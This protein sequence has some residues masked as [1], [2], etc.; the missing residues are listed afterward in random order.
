MRAADLD[1][2]PHDAIVVGAG[3]AGAVTAL[4]LARHGYRVLLLDRHRFPRAKPCG[5]CLSPEAAR[6]LDRLGLLPRVAALEPARLRGWR[7]WSPDGAWFRGD[8]EAAAR[9]DARAETSI[10]VARERLDAALLDA[11][12]EAGVELRAPVT[13]EDLIVGPRGVEGIVGRTGGTRHRLRA[14]LVVGADGLRSVVAR[15][16]GATRRPGALRKV[17]F[18][19]HPILPAGFSGDVGEM[20]VVTGGCIGIAPVEA[21]RSGFPIAHNVT[22]VM[23]R[24]EGGGGMGLDPHARMRSLAERAPGLRDR[25]PVLFDAMA[26]CDSPLASGPFDRPVRFVVADGLA[27]VGD[28]A[29][30][31]DP[32]TGQGVCHALEAGERLAGVAAEALD[33]AGESVP[34]RRLRPYARWVARAHRPARGVQRAIEFVTARPSLM[35]RFTIALNDAPAFAD[36]LIATTGDLAPVRSLAG[37]PAASLGLALLRQERLR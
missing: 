13:V 29:G 18:T 35:R 21:A 28:A 4:G 30:Y 8:F 37:A 11:A 7:I 14:R 5:D 1:P 32:F 31:Y 22:F 12:L 23:G 24:D 19:L 10:A 17:S 9:G 2:V 16:A 25:L 20:H 36:A 6:V 26:R 15:R 3:P 33:Y 34:A 27:L